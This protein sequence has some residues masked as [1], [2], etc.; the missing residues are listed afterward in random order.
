MDGCVHVHAC[1]VVGGN[2]ERDSLRARAVQEQHLDGGII[3]GVRRF[4][5]G[6]YRVRVSVLAGALTLEDHV[7]PAHELRAEMPALAQRPAGEAVQTKCEAW[8]MERKASVRVA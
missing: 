7:R 6:Q 4:H 5:I 2:H 3:A 1:L 8:L